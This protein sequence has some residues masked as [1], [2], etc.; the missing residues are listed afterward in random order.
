MGT[1]VIKVF[2]FSIVSNWGFC[3]IKTSFFKSAH[4]GAVTSAR[5]GMNL[6]ISSPKFFEVHQGIMVQTFF[7]TMSVLEG[8]NLIP[9]EEIICPKNTIESLRN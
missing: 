9:S 5:F 2:N 6:P 3:K 1:D 8:S 4:S 7:V